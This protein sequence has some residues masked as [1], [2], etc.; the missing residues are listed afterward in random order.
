MCHTILRVQWQ[1]NLI[2]TKNSMQVTPLNQRVVARQ[3][4]VDHQTSSGLILQ[5]DVLNDMIVA[6]VI[7]VDPSY[8]GYELQGKTI[9]YPNGTGELLSIDGE[10]YDIV[11]INSIRAIIA[12]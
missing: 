11:P 4:K 12:Q 7:A 2:I 3:K 9:I 6:E 1:R 8:Q 10:M 5:A